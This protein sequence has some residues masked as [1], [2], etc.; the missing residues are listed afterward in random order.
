MT[1]VKPEDLVEGRKYRVVKRSASAYDSC[2]GDVIEFSH[3][4]TRRQFGFFKTNFRDVHGQSI[5]GEGCMLL[6][7]YTPDTEPSLDAGFITIITVDKRDNMTR[8]PTPARIHFNNVGVRY[9]DSFDENGKL[10]QGRNE[11]YAEPTDKP[12]PY[13][14][15]PNDHQ[16]KKVDDLW[17]AMPHPP[18]GGY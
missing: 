6:E 1:T 8:E 10:L 9:R 18:K 2:V 5:R 12:K 17:A 4:C 7:E 3:H 14:A 11:D 13:S 15:L 16:R